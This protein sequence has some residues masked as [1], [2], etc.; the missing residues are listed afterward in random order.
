ML[1]DRS[2][3]KTP[4]GPLG[5]LCEP[6]ALREMLDGSVEELRGKPETTLVSGRPLSGWRSELRDAFGL[7][8]PAI[9]TGHQV[10]FYHAGVFAKVVAAHHLA[11]RSGGSAL[12]VGVDSDT[13]KTARLTTTRIS[14]GAA[15]RVEVLI[16]GVDM[17]VS[18]EAQ[19]ALPREQWLEFFARVA[20]LSPDYESSGLRAFADGWLGGA[21]ERVAISAAM[22]RGHEG[23]Q[24]ALGVKPTPHVPVSRLCTTP[25]FSAFF[26]QIAMNAARF[27]KNY[28]AAQT[29]YRARHRVRSDQ[30]PVPPLVVDCDQVELPFWMI[31]GAGRRKR[32]S[33]DRARG[34][35]V[36][37][38]SAD[39]SI[40]NALRG[41]QE[42]T[43]RIRPRALTLTLFLRLFV[44][45]AFIHGIG[46]AKYDEIT[47]ELSREFFGA[48]AAPIACV[49]ATLSLFG[50]QQALVPDELAA[51]RLAVRDLRH[52]PERYVKGIDEGLIAERDELLRE[53]ARLRA[54]DRR[55][56]AARRAIHRSLR[57]VHDRMLA[58]QP[59]LGSSLTQRVETLL[60]RSRDEKLRADREVFYG[61]H[62]LSALR[63]LVSAIRGAIGS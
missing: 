20:D 2:R 6:S 16:P 22:S 11:E 57:A 3:L 13:P 17:D 43:H 9:V 42:G 44:A 4:A 31:D 53:A 61:F 49:S 37:G 23:L 54:N 63:E 41:I 33:L 47:D 28:N 48:A 12:F 25:A 27:A 60:S 21:A 46:G 38:V 58:V 30:R 45:D 32:L 24:D 7:V 29:A 15:Q 52:N 36:E 19:E 5:V 18:M 51:A 59:W 1:L 26:E 39:I 40:Q 62:S 56:R 14:H 10:E 34:L 35:R 55:N 8:E 50:E